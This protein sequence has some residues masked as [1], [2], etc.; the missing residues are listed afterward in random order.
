[1]TLCHWKEDKKGII[2]W[3]QE[4]KM[5]CW[6]CKSLSQVVIL[7]TQAF[8]SFPHINAFTLPLRWTPSSHIQSYTWPKACKGSVFVSIRSRCGWKDMSLELP[9]PLLT[10]TFK[11]ASC[12]GVR[13]E[14]PLWRKETVNPTQ[15]PV[16]HSW[17]LLDQALWS[18]PALAAK[19]QPWEDADWALEEASPCSLF[20]LVSSEV[21]AEDAL[22]WPAWPLELPP[23]HQ[24]CIPDGCLSPEQSKAFKV[25]TQKRGFWSVCF[26]VP[27]NTIHF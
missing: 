27:A 23:G 7:V 22:P 14:Y 8:C 16:W 6:H 19:G 18:S 12:R 4:E 3:A 1:M 9:S 24:G 11:T 5:G 20:P 25:Q 15:T 26:D 2:C 10:H 21:S 13:S 17:S